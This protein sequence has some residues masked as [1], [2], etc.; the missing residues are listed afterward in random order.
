[1]NSTMIAA[2]C[3]LPTVPLAALILYWRDRRRAERQ[4]AE[5]FAADVEFW[6]VVRRV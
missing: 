1:M 4:A 5:A 2:L 3:A 6:T